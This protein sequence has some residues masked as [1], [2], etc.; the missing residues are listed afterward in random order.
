MQKV[1]TISLLSLGNP[2]S[3]PQWHPLCSAGNTIKPW[4]SNQWCVVHNFLLCICWGKPLP[5]LIDKVRPS[6]T[7]GG[8]SFLDCA[9][10]MPCAPVLISLDKV[11]YDATCSG[12]AEKFDL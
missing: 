3:L 8:V 10:L 12:E 9:K 1:A 11:I 5:V 6:G 4:G 7:V 2:I